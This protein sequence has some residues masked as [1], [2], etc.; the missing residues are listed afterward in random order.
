MHGL[1]LSGKGGVAR[2]VS[3]SDIGTQR[4]RHN[5]E[6]PR[7]PIDGRERTHLL[8]T[9]PPGI[10]GFS[11]FA[12]PLIGSSATARVRSKRSTAEI[13]QSDCGIAKPPGFAGDGLGDEEGRQ[14]DRLESAFYC[15]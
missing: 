3:G 13:T 5:Q 7:R 1:L 15:L 11:G 12:I 10:F 8:K 2:T 6:R 9:L 14:R 4:S